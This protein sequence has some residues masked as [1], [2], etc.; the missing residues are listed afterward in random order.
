MIIVLRV[1]RS[2]SLK[3]LQ[4]SLLKAEQV[5]RQEKQR[6]RGLSIFPSTLHHLPTHMPPLFQRITLVS[7]LL[8]SVFHIL[9]IKYLKWCFICFFPLKVG[10]NK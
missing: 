5:K 7:F 1:L 10:E 2:L 8:L 6:V 4:V 9:Y 3:L